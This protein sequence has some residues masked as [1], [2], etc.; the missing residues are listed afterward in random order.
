MFVTLVLKSTKSFLLDST[1]S[2]NWT[3]GRQTRGRL[4]Q[5]TAHRPLTFGNG[6]DGAKDHLKLKGLTLKVM[7]CVNM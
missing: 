2:F 3:D 1:W 7:Q 6:G 5:S 4:S